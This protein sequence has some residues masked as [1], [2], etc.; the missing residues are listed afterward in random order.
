MLVMFQLKS[1]AMP[2]KFS[3]PAMFLPEVNRGIEI[4]AFVRI[5]QKCDKYGKN[6]PDL[7]HKGVWRV[8][9]LLI[10]YSLTPKKARASHLFWLI[11][12]S[13]LL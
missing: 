4:E 3:L 8:I 5:S 12:I 6:C 9:V 7:S 10:Y 11:F 2:S 1:S 13:S